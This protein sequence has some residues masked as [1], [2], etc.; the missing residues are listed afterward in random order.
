MGSVKSRLTF[1]RV[2]SILGRMAIKKWT[3]FVLGAGASASSGL[4]SGQGLVGRII[5]DISGARAVEVAKWID[6]PLEA[7]QE[8]GRKL[9]LAST[10]SID[11]WLL[12]HPRFLPVGKVLICHAINAF[13]NPGNLRSGG[14][15]AGADKWMFDLWNRMKDGLTTVDQLSRNNVV[16]V[17]FNYD[18]SLEAFF[19]DAI[20]NTF[21]CTEEEAVGAVRKIQIIHVHGQT[22]F[23]PWQKRRGLEVENV[24]SSKGEHDDGAWRLAAKC[25]PS[26]RLVSEV[27]LEA[28][29]TDAR[30]RLSTAEQIAFLG[31]GYHASNLAKLQ[32]RE[33]QAQEIFGTF[34]D[35]PRS[36]ETISDHASNGFGKGISLFAVDCRTLLKGHLKD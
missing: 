23:L 9:P 18:R 2:R 24:Y 29:I 12:K 1:V 36:M 10:S 5:N 33:E 4:P 17:T 11:D 25:A 15:P 8:I 3:V 13:E 16:F 30:L 35:A 19:F 26:I 22:G 7:V 27:S 14:G 34:V 31:M 21:D 6:A 20:H 28:A 32:Y